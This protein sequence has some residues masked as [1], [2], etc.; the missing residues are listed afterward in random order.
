MTLPE[1]LTPQSPTTNLLFI[2]V[3]VWSAG[4]L[5]RKIKQPPV[6]GELTAGIIFGPAMLGF[7][8]PDG[9]VTVLAE[10]GAFFL[11]FYAG[12]ETNP[13]DLKA[14]RG[15]AILV[16]FFGFL[17]PF[18][19]GYTLCLLF[20]M[21]QIQAMFIGLGLSVTAIAVNARVLNDCK[22]QAY[23]VVPVIIGAAIIDDVCSFALFSVIIGLAAG[24][25]E[26]IYWLLVVDLFKVLL[27]FGL[28]C[29]IGI[30]LYPSF[31]PH[32]MGREAKGFT[33][34]L[35]MAL[36]FGLMAEA[37]GLHIIIGAYMA[38]LFVREEIVHPALFQKINDRFVAITYGFLG[39]IFFVSLAFHITFD[40]FFTHTL[41]IVV[42]L[43]IAVL[44]KVLGC[45]VVA[46][47]AGM[48]RRESTVVAMA[49]NGRGAVELVIASVGIK[50]GIIDDDL[51]SILVVIAFVTTMIPPF[52][53]GQYLRPGLHGLRRL[54]ESK[55]RKWLNKPCEGDDSD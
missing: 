36:V 9:M 29:G 6:L 23:V 45:G 3:L 26:P 53:L 33:F 21:A 52:A 51:F 31:A 8:Q 44:G 30:Y 46:R 16:G 37:A 40:I 10:L 32:F 25:N 12:L 4:V 15:T 35:I 42:L 27:F 20:G 11:M 5:F 54:E 50:L 55:R 17:V 43:L 19:M 14:H 47:L 18:L 34:A 1:L 13:F 24:G 2:M 7:I 22:L 39:P 48:N 41:L 38:G 28:T 49:M